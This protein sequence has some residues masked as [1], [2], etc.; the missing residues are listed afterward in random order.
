[1]V[2]RA[3]VPAAGEGKRMQSTL[4][5]QFLPLRGQPVLAWTLKALAA[6]PEIVDI[7]VVVKADE[8][9]YCRAEVVEK[10]GLQEKVRAIIPGGERRQDSV[11]LGLFD[12][13]ADTELV[14]VH[15]GARPLIRPGKIRE[16]ILA[17]ERNEAVTVALPLKDTIKEVDMTGKVVCTPDRSRFW[18]VQT[19]QVFSY[20]LLREAHERQ[21]EKDF[22]DDASLVESLGYPVRVLLGDYDNLKITT[23][24]D[25]VMAEALLQQRQRRGGEGKMRVGIGYDVHR[26]VEGQPLILGGVE[27]PFPYGL[28]G[29]SDADVL[30]HAIMDALLGSAALGDLG[31][32]FPDSD[33]AWAGISSLELLRRVRGMLQEAGLAVQNIDSVIVAQRPKLAPYIPAMREKVAETLGIAVDR[34]SIK[35]TTTEGLGFAGRG[36]GIAAEAVVLVE[37]KRV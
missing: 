17:G 10:Y 6:V 9:S 26:L 1:M 32:H 23:P 7:T 22:T 4:N 11:R 5:K 13:P 19:P 12:L 8:I 18:T 21:K 31:K 25:L 34:V 20:R 28:L 16:A 33:P 30:V 35:A 2:V 24:E 27:I 3:I 15:D 14:V 29:H 36:E 37:E